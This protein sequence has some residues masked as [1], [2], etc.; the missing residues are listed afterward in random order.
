MTTQEQ[1]IAALITSLNNLVAAQ[2]QATRAVHDMTNSAHQASDE[3]SDLARAGAGGRKLTEEEI[4]LKAKLIEAINHEVSASRRKTQAEEALAALNAERAKQTRDE[5]R[6]STA[7]FRQQHTAALNNVI[8]ARS[9]H[10]ATQSA[11][12]SLRTGFVASVSKAV[13]SL[14]TWVGLLAKIGTS[15]LGFNKTF[16]DATTKSGGVIEESTGNFDQGMSQWITSLGMST[17][18]QG[19]IALGL[20]AENRQMVNAVGGISNAIH[21][22]GD[23]IMSMRGFYGGLEESM[24]ATLGIMTEFAT[25]GVQPTTD[26]LNAYNKDL[27]MLSMQTGMAPTAINAMIDAIAD[28]T[29]SIH[30]LRSAR[31][32][33]RGALLASERALLKNNIALGMSAK[34]AEEAAKMLNKMVAQKPLDRLKQAAKMRAMGAAMGLG[35][36]AAAAAKAVE[37]GPRATAEQ[38]ADLNSFNIQMTGMVDQSAQQ[39]MAQELFVTEMLGKL[40]MNEYY[41][42]SSPFSATLGNIQAVSTEILSANYKSSSD[43]TIVA[44]NN[45]A[46]ISLG[47]LDTIISGQLAWNELIQATRFIGILIKD[48]ISGFSAF[49]DNVSSLFGGEEAKPTDV[50]PTNKI[51]TNTTAQPVTTQGE[52]SA[53]PLYSNLTPEMK[54][55]YMRP[56]AKTA[57]ENKKLDD[58]NTAKINAKMDAAIKGETGAKPAPAKPIEPVAKPVPALEPIA[59]PIEPV[60]KP[61]PTP[62][63]LSTSPL[64]ILPPVIPGEAPLVRIVPDTIQ[65]SVMAMHAS[66]TTNLMSDQVELVTQQNSKIDQQLSNMT[67]SNQYLKIIADTNPILVDLAEKQLAVSTMNQVQ[68]DKMASRMNSENAKFSANYSYAL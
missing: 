20:L 50:A 55:A 33:E 54:K 16:M 4:K 12:A 56:P 38:R 68:K 61:V 48:F 15:L 11:T 40:D 59:K 43:S 47:I 29:E 2:S 65:D 57:E 62:A 22:T 21:L 42:P 7:S 27:T 19:D 10:A 34:Q 60:A 13:S 3:I 30:L 25:K 5:R 58:E 49:S 26:A 14:A 51:E 31:E 9:N 18:I 44:V 46:D 23:S 32:G 1:Q 8:S 45:V 28:D 39:G 6:L 64:N 67:S 66:E 36:E 24:K 35:S 17:G 41:G 53:N 37:A 52:P 63:P